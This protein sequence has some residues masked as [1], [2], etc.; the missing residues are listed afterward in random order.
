M[1]VCLEHMVGTRSIDLIN[2]ELMTIKIDPENKKKLLITGHSKVRNDEKLRDAL[3]SPRSF[4]PV[5][6][7]PQEVLDLLQRYRKITAVDVRH[8]KDKY[9]DQIYELT[10]I[11]QTHFINRKLSQYYNKD[12]VNSISN[13]YPEQ[14]AIAAQRIPRQH[15]GSH[16]ARALSVQLSI[17]ENMKPDGS[18][19]IYMRDHLQHAGFGSAP[20]YK[21]VKFIEMGN[22]GT[23]AT[24]VDKELGSKLINQ[25]VEYRT[26]QKKEMDLLREE[27][28]EL[29]KSKGV[30]VVQ[31]KKRK[32]AAHRTIVDVF[33]T[34]TDREGNNH[35]LKK[36]KRGPNHST[37]EYMQERVTNVENILKEKNIN[38]SVAN[39]KRMGIGSRS[40][41]VLRSNAT[42]QGLATDYKSEKK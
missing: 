6:G 4:F 2:E 9:Q 31:I 41:N 8:I 13:W 18:P 12:L 10:G 11:Q 30:D 3:A 19:D 21:Q 27:I 5:G 17:F 28:Y 36:L 1:G 29:K 35:V 26:E 39:I 24:I 16:I 38:N 14:A 34:L 42:S 37:E 23:Y 25:V 22:S 33:V 32:V 20:H 7:S 15:F 40:I